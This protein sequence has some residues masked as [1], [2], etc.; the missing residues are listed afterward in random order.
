MACAVMLEVF[1]VIMH[2]VFC[3]VPTFSVQD[4]SNSKYQFLHLPLSLGG[5][6]LQVRVYG[7][8]RYVSVT[9]TYH[10]NFMLLGETFIELFSKN[11]CRS[12]PL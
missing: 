6:M 9:P 10:K 11:F 7:L 4:I 1:V 8:G 5:A 12:P 2:D 3:A